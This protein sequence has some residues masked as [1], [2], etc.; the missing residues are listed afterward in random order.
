MGKI[1]AIDIGEKRTG[2]AETDP[3]RIIASPKA[4]V[5]TP[6]LMPYLKTWLANEPAEIIVLGYPT[7]LD[8]Q[9]TDNTARVLQWQKDLQ[10]AFSNAQVVLHDER[11]TSKLAAQALYKSGVKK[12]KRQ[13]KGALDAISAALILEDYLKTAAS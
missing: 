1:I 12:K 7:H 3:M 2:L 8:G 6:E 11:F 10:S 13:Q 9:A 5:L 4:T